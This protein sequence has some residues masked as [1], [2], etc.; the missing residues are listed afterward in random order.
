MIYKNIYDILSFP[1]RIKIIQKDEIIP[2][3]DWFIILFINRKYIKNNKLIIFE[4]TNTFLEKDFKNYNT[5]PPIKKDLFLR[6]LNEYIE[7]LS[8]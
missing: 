1:E 7:E 8:E 6:A 2:I 3:Y 5:N 4:L